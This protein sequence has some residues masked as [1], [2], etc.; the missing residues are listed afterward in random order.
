MLKQPVANIKMT[1][2]ATIKYK[3]NNKMFEIACYRNKALN[4][5]NGVE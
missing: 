3:I 5:R 2:V 4:F 1:N